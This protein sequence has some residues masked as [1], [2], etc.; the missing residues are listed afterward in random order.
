MPW[1]EAL[2]DTET[3]KLF[4]GLLFTALKQALPLINTI[5]LHR[6]ERKVNEHHRVCK[7]HRE[8]TRRHRL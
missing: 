4:L 7:E 2:K 3:Q 5:R 1:R 6:L 8:N